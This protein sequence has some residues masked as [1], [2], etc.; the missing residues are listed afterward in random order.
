MALSTMRPA[1]RARVQG[2]ATPM[3]GGGMPGMPMMMG[4][5]GGMGGMAGMAGMGGMNPMAMGMMPHMGMMPQMGMGV[6]AAAPS[7]VEEHSEAEECGE[8]ASAVVPAKAAPAVPATLDVDGPPV[9]QRI[10]DAAISR[11]CTY[12]KSFP[13]NRLADCLQGL[14]EKLDA[15]YLAET[16]GPGLLAC[17]WLLPGSSHVSVCQTF[18]AWTDLHKVCCCC[19]CCSSSCCCCFKTIATNITQEW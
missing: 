13:R 15:A 10:Q 9:H 7:E 8:P 16:T 6:A 1:K 11:S 17:L 18:V 14:C 19:C 4:G 5:M 3:M 2:P 12:V